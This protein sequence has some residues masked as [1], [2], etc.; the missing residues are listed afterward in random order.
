MV[1]VRVNGQDSP[2]SCAATLRIAD[3][4]ELVKASIDPEH[5]ITGIMLD[6]RAIEEKDWS[7]P[8]TAYGTAIMEVSTD[9]P[10]A[11]VRE[12]IKIAPELVGAITSDLND[13]KQAF[14]QGNTLEGNRRLV[15]AVQSLR[16]FFDWYGSILELIPAER[17]PLFDVS[18]QVRV[19]TETCKRICQYQLYASWWALGEAIDKDLNPQLGGLKTTFDQMA[20]QV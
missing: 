14:Q 19:M 7:Q 15:P 20:Q 8:V 2:V 17:R 4:V 11:F 5:M 10:E 13:A 6:G 12:R 16:A 3:V 1:G 18:P 9:R